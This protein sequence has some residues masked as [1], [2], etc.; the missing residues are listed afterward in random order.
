MHNLAS[1]RHRAKNRTFRGPPTPSRHA[2]A[3]RRL[4]SSHINARVITSKVVQKGC[5]AG[6]R[7]V[8]MH[9]ESNQA[10]YRNAKDGCG[11]VRFLRGP[12][13]QL[14]RDELRR[15]SHRLHRWFDLGSRLG[16]RFQ[17]SSHFVPVPATRCCQESNATYVPDSE[18][19]EAKRS[20]SSSFGAGKEGLTA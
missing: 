4:P 12:D 15:K 2:A 19:Y 14:T 11:H 13:S 3:P 1:S 8:A 9:A 17:A 7:N 10:I 5:K 16:L 6:T 18:V 20:R